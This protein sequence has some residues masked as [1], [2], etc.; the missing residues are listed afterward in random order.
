[1][2][3]RYGASLA[4]R[5]IS[6]T[7][8]R[9]E[10]CV[11]IGPSGCGKTTCLDAMAGEVVPT[12]GAV[13]VL[14]ETPKS[15]NQRI[16]YMFARD[17]LL[18]WR[19]ARGNVELALESRGVRRS[20]RH[21]RAAELLD[22]VG[23]AGWY[24]SYP[25]QLSHGMR[26]R[27]ALARTFAVGAELLLMDEPFGALDGQTRIL[28]EQELTRLWEQDSS[29]VVFVTHDLA[30]A[31]VLADRVVVMSAR[32]GTIKNVVP[33]PFPRPRSMTALHA[34]PAFRD[35][36]EGIRLELEDEVTR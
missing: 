30:E 29:T 36:H 10:F 19:T 28:L 18:P 23:L 7:V 31:I 4:I 13:T 5:D 1:V 22:S 9:G 8:R 3:H 12:S 17:A 2:S 6:L 21:R 11:L 14:G 27:V 15:G 32:P 25:S 34:L 20:D 35:L 26:Q 33:V 24:D 16:G